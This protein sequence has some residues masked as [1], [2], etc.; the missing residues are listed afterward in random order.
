MSYFEV[1]SLPYKSMS[2]PYSSE[3]LRRFRPRRKTNKFI[4]QIQHEKNINWT[5]DDSHVC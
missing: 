1:N 5:E 4:V 3:L 2:G